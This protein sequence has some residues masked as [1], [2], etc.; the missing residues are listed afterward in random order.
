[1]IRLLTVIVG[2][3]YIASELRNRKLKKS[4]GKRVF[5][6]KLITNPYMVLFINLFLNIGMN[7]LQYYRDGLT[8]ATIELII[9]NTVMF[10]VICSLNKNRKAIFEGGIN[11]GGKYYSWEQVIDYK[12]LPKEKSSVLTIRIDHA[13][14]G[15]K[16][17]KYKIPM[18]QVEHVEEVLVKGN[19]KEEKLNA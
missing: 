19:S 5:V 9:F 16:N 10:L 8:S 3:L 18:R 7:V 2:V 17:I 6:I 12:W 14:S 11:T 1:M 4:L 13:I 15:E